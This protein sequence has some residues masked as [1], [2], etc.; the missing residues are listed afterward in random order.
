ML[1][2]TSETEKEFR[3]IM[4]EYNDSYVEPLSAEE[5]QEVSQ[6]CK[7]YSKRFKNSR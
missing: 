7:K 5:F 4:D 2:T 6:Y 1:F 3:K